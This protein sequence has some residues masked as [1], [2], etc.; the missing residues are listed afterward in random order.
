M[1]LWKLGKQDIY[2]NNI[3]DEEQGFFSKKYFTAFAPFLIE[4]ILFF[5]EMARKLYRECS[6]FIHGN[7]STYKVLPESL[8]YEEAVFR[9]WHE[10]AETARL[11]VVFSLCVRYLGELSNDDKRILEICIMDHIGHVKSIEQLFQVYKEGIV[12]G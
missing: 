4:E 10:K 3:I 8:R 5:R 6:E 12:N 9:D 11:L 2:W 7:Y 1:R